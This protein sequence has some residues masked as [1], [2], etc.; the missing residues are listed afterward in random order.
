ME[1]EENASSGPFLAASACAD[2]VGLVRAFRLSCSAFG[3]SGP[4]PLGL[5]CPFY[6]SSLGF[7]LG[8]LLVQSMPTCCLAHPPGA[9]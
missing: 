8:V 5:C 9:E 4:F 6:S 2:V 1:E 7:V 3:L